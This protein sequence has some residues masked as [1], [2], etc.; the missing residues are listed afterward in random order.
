MYDF[1]DMDERSRELE[2]QVDESEFE[3]P[4]EDE[5]EELLADDLLEDDEDVEYDE[6]DYDDSM[7][8]DHDSNMRDIG[9][10]TD[11][12]YGYYG[13]NEDWS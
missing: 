9:W 13:E 5:L 3:A 4:S 11:E 12:D 1:D 2:E 6:D 7:D 10:G 8:G